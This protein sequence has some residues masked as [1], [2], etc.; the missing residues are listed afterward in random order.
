MCLGQLLCF[1]KPGTRV[2][3]TERQGDRE[4]QKERVEE[5]KAGRGLQGT[6]GEERR[7]DQVE[8]RLRR[9]RILCIGEPGW[10]LAAVR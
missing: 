9:W 2:F 1:K 10:Y 5:R 3:K 7:R 6:H 8:S 4:E